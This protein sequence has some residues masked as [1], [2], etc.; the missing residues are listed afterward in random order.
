MTR[1]LATTLVGR[2][3]SRP[4]DSQTIFEYEFALESPGLL[5]DHRVD[6]TTVVAGAYQLCMLLASATEV[7]GDRACIVDQVRF[8]Q[9][10]IPPLVGRQSVQLI[11]T[12]AETG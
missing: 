2:R 11:L 7:S 12:R 1:R 3:R 10:I 9:A 6:G 8:V 5:R 4:F